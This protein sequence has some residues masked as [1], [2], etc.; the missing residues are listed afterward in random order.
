MNFSPVVEAGKTSLP[1]WLQFLPDQ[2]VLRGI[3]Q[4]ED[5]GALYLEVLAY[6][7]DGSKATDVF[8][9]SISG[10]AATLSSGQPLTFRKSGP[11]VVRCKREEPET[12]ATIIVDGDLNA[13]PV[14][15]RLKLLTGFLSHMG[16]TEEVVKMIPAAANLLQDDTALV[17]GTGD[18]RD[19]QHP[20]VQISWLVGCGKVEQ[21]HFPVL[22]KLDDDSGSGRMKEAVGFPI[23]GWRVTNSR[24]QQHAP[25]RRR[26]QTRATAT[27][28]ITISPPTAT[29]DDGTDA[30]DVDTMT[31]SV[32]EMTSPT[33]TIQPTPTEPEMPKTMTTDRMPVTTPKEE[34]PVK[35]TR[36]PVTSTEGD[37]ETTP[38]MKPTKPPTKPT[39]KPIPPTGML[40]ECQ[41]PDVGE[42]IGRVTA[43]VGEILE[44]QIPDN[45]FL[46]PC[47]LD[48]AEQISLRLFKGSSSK[49]PDDFW[50]KFDEEK[51]VIMGIPS[52]K[53]E[54][55]QSMTLVANLKDFEGGPISTMSFKI[56]V[57]N[58]SG[59]KGKV[60]HEVAMTIDTDY[61]KFVS[62]V[63]A[64]LDLAQK[65]AGAFGDEDTSALTVTGVRKGSVI[66]AWTNNTM[67][68]PGCP[69]DDAKAMA[70]KLVSDDGNLRAETIEKLKPWKLTGASLAPAGD[71]EGNADFPIVS[72]TA[73]TPPPTSAD[74]STT[75]MPDDTKTKPDM[76]DVTMTPKPTAPVANMTTPPAK[77]GKTS[78]DDIWITTVV[79]AVVI[80]AILLIA[81]LIACILYRKKRKG[82][83]N[84]EDQNTFVNK[85]APVIFPDELDDKPGDSS[86]PLLIEGSPPAP[87]PEYHRG[88]SES[89]EPRNN[90]KEATP[91]T[92]EMDADIETDVTSPLY[93]PPPPVTASSGKSARPH[94]QQ[95]YRS[96]PP[97][98]HP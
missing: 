26:R 15:D 98:I 7:N 59:R 43:N 29:D 89:P 46:M 76:P 11:E 56:V 53:D 30:T 68:G 28:V 82:K 92:D 52:V 54:G 23:V 24:L 70:G 60:N 1:S 49:I 66:Y 48:G 80:V 45:A 73:L 94:V 83:M 84:L 64:K 10:D 32:V 74:T 16:L 62:N 25:K 4:R 13:M 42:Q 93:Q 86:K 17:T 58:P 90:H 3:P 37:K 18:A 87:P 79:P 5:A 27:P 44:Y 61:D 63:S 85:G 81:L 67:S 51:K 8:S 50:F 19:P 33:F 2:N 36:P 39:V 91:P 96:Q 55:R 57:K 69:V 41:K 6:G 78:E 71:C 20:G 9:V 97:E 88:T 14:D 38:S 35:P 75:A 12:V 72:A 40:P 65:I 31:R 34:K 77:A 22:Q 21:G 95:P 47:G